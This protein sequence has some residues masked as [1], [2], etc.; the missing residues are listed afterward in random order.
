MRESTVEA[1]FFRYDEFEAG[2]KV[3]GKV[4]QIDASGWVHVSLAPNLFGVINTFHQGATM[5]S[6]EAQKS[7]FRGKIWLNSNGTYIY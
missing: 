4:Q 7:R 1:E 6:D 2:Q 5:L 3:T